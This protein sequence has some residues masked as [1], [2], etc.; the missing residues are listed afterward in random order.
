MKIYPRVIFSALL[1]HLPNLLVKSANKVR[2][3]SFFVFYL[4]NKVIIVKS[5]KKKKQ[6]QKKLVNNNIQIRFLFYSLNASIQK[7]Y[8][9]ILASF[10]KV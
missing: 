7:Q 4:K 2:D 9:T 10:L 6:K 8:I 3:Y 5:S 1:K